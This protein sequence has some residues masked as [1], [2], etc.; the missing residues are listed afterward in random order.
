MGDTIPYQY[1]VTNTGTRTLSNVA[2]N[3]NLVSS[4]SCPDSSLAPGAAEICTGG[5]TATQA[6]V[7]AGSVT[8]T[9]T[10][11]ATDP[12]DNSIT[13][14]S[15]SVTV[16]RTLLTLTKSAVSTGYGAAGDVVSYQYL[17]TNAT[18]GTLTNISVS[19]N[20]V[21]SVSCPDSSLAPS[22]SETCTG[23]YTVSQADVDNGSVTNTAQASAVDS[24]QVTVE[25]GSASVTVQALYATTSLSLMKSTTSTGY[26][27]AGDTIPYDYLVTNTGTTTLSGITVNDNKVAHVSCPSGPLSPEASETCT[28]S[29]TVAQADVD[30]GSVTNTATA[31]GSSS[32]SDG[33]VNSNSSSVTV[34]ASN[35]TSSLGLVKAT[36]T[37]TFTGAGKVLNYTYKVTD[38]GS[39]TV[40][41]ISVSD[42]KVAH[43]SCPSGPLA[44]GASLTCTG[45][46]TATQADANANGVTNTATAHGS[47]DQNDDPVSSNSASLTVHYTGITITTAS[48]LPTLTLG[49]AYSH[50]LTVSGAPIPKKVRWVALGT[51][52]K[53]LHVSARGLL[54]GSLSPKHVVP[55]TYSLTIEVTDGTG[56]EYVKTLSL[57]IQA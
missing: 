47:S 49:A 13:S 25:S 10:A 35:A 12:G 27:A 50:Q 8:N 22:D 2:V 23:S 48:P 28:G 29:Y 42:N 6:D 39:T 38:S 4:V 20:L 52:P 44:P 40:S 7:D 21:S 26:G 9:A 51:L 24:D 15:S 17:V 43:V 36:S 41:G 19:D 37:P 1:V 45:S 16:D 18:L 46:Y 34:N 5:Y 11:T 54:H 31:S 33:P 53:G 56:Q 57:R 30:A 32:L 3:D 14:N 55:G